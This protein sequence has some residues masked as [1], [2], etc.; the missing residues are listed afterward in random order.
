MTSYWPAPASA[1]A[2]R[3]PTPRIRP[4]ELEVLLEL[5][6]S[7]AAEAPKHFSQR[8]PATGTLAALRWLKW[9][10][11]HP[12]IV[13]QDDGWKSALPRSTSCHTL[14]FWF[15]TTSRRDSEARRSASNFIFCMSLTASSTKAVSLLNLASRSKS[16]PRSSREEEEVEEEPVV[17]VSAMCLSGSPRRTSG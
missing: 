3:P 10:K 12:Q 8:F 14:V 13:F 5:G 16:W 6:A 4:Y 11:R 17:A 15:S 7:H 9:A 2:L 1:E